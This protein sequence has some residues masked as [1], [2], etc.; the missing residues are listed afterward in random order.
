MKETEWFSVT[1]V[2]VYKGVYKTRHRINDGTILVGWSYFDGFRW[3][4]TAMTATSAKAGASS[5]QSR[6]WCG[7]TTRE[8]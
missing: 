5:Q 2:P 4:Y 1:V 6:E 7:L 3:G 8:T